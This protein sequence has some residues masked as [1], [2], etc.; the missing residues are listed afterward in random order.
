MYSYIRERISRG[1]IDL[2][3]FKETALEKF[4]IQHYEHCLTNIS[5]NSA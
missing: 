1:Q 2:N 5:K 4:Q 3:F